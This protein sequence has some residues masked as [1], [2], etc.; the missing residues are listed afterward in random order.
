M[1]RLAGA[2]L[3][4]LLV[5][6]PS[7]SADD[8][9][10]KKFASEDGIE[11]RFDGFLSYEGSVEW[12]GDNAFDEDPEGTGSGYGY[13]EG[14]A[15]QTLGFEA[16]L[17]WTS[18]VNGEFWDS[19]SQELFVDSVYATFD[20]DEWW[21]EVGK[22]NPLFSSWDMGTG[23]YTGLQSDDLS[24]WGVLGVLVERELD[25]DNSATISI[26]SFYQ[27]TST[28][29]GS[30]I[31]D[32]D[33][34][35]LG[36]GGVGNTGELNN[37]FIAISGEDPFFDTSWDYSLGVVYQSAGE[38][39]E[40]REVSIY[41]TLQGY[42]TAGE[43]TEINPYLEVVHRDGA[44]GEERNATTFAVGMVLEQDAWYAG[45]SLS[46][47]RAEDRLDSSLDDPDL[48][49]EVFY[50]N[51]DRSLELFAGFI[52]DSGA[53]VDFGYQYL[54]EFGESTNFV[55]LAVG[56]AFNFGGSKI[57]HDDMRRMTR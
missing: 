10:E 28:L 21:V 38:T 54:D 46:L 1:L 43:S 15:T 57:N 26:G 27:D 53:Y 56:F 19:D 24:V 48:F 49:P 9:P 32:D 14:S 33:D 3:L 4:G 29:S 20:Y 7:T 51:S 13:F 12:A 18:G 17:S 41:S 5:A 44:D 37:G 16:E 30:I 55:S 31:T 40:N 23:W 42:Y 2:L 25:T 50:P 34:V 11:S 22:L 39:E 6:A 52:H 36:D 35:E 47:R 8:V 45:I